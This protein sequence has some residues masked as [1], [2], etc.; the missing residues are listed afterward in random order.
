MKKSFGKQQNFMDDRMASEKYHYPRPP[1]KREP[2]Q[3]AV[4]AA[5]TRK[6]ARAATHAGDGGN[7]NARAANAGAG[8]IANGARGD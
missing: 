3:S 8:V 4:A 2:A 5:A 6:I 7:I 1:R